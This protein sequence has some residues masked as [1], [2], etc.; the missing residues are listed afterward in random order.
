[1]AFTG[2][3]VFEALFKIFAF[4][5]QKYFVNAWNLFDFTV[6]LVCLVGVAT[7]TLAMISGGKSTSG[8]ALIRVLRVARIFRLIPKAK[9]LLRLF[10]TLYVSLPALANVGAVM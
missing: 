3:F 7:D 4:G 1:M 5:P 10:K 8:L 2:I 6:V 9:R